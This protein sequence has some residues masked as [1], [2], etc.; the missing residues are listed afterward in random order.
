VQRISEAL[1]ER[2]DWDVEGALALQR[3]VLSLVWRDMRESVLSAPREDPQVRRAVDLLHPWDGEMD[4]GSAPAAL[5]SLFVAELTRRAAAAW[6]PRSLEWA[7]GRGTSPIVPWTYV[8]LRQAGH[9]AGLL[10]ERPEG[11][12][13]DGW[14]AEIGRA[15]VS[16]LSDLEAAGT[17]GWGTLRPLTVRHPLGARRLFAR[18]FDLGPIPYGGDANTVSQASNPPLDATGA[19]LYVATLRVVW[20]VGDWERSRVSLAGGQSGNPL[21]PHY[22]DLFDRWRRGEAVPLPFSE[23]A[24]AQA[25][26]STL[27]LEPA[28]AG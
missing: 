6:A 23:A 10:R 28:P 2:E 15:L 20:D 25:T 14:D 22:S 16:A 7:L 9:V 21:S 1:A 11:W 8:A 5:F 18:A 13:A 17:P 3:D 27:R 26:A 12:F 24:V 4:A 19:P